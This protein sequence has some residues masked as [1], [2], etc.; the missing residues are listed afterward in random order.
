MTGTTQPWLDQ[1][2]TTLTHTIH[3][4]IYI[5]QSTLSS[6]TDGY[7]DAQKHIQGN[8]NSNA[9]GQCVGRGITFVE[10]TISFSH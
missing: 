2:R 7:R 3:I 9:L 6:L 8:L 4:S 5:T 1:R 10:N